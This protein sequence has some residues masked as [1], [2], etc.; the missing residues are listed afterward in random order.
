MAHRQPRTP[1]RL[2]PTHVPPLA[3]VLLVQWAAAC[4]E[5]SNNPSRSEGTGE[6]EGDAGSDAGPATGDASVDDDAGNP[7]FTP[8]EAVCGDGA[9]S[10]S[11][12]CDDGNEAS[13]DGCSGSCDEVEP[14]FACPVAGEYCVRF[15]ICGNARIEG[16]E[17]CDDR[18]TTGGDGCSA[19]CEREL[20][21]SCP[22]V[23][24]ACGAASCGDGYR[25]GFEGC[26][27]GNVDAGDGCDASCHLEEGHACPIPGAACVATV[28][29]DGVAEGTEDCDDMN[30][31]VGDGCTPVCTYEPS[32]QDGTCAAVCGDG[33][34]WAPETCDDG[35]SLSGDGCSSDCQ[36]EVGFACVEVE[37]AAPAE[38]QLP[39]TIRDF[40][41]ACGGGSR[42]PDDNGNAV[43]PYGHRDFE[44]YNGGG[45]GMVMANLGANGK[46][47]RIANN[48]T[49]SDASFG[50]WYVT[51][52]DYNRAHA[53]TLVLP[54]IGG[55]AYQ[56]INNDFFP[57]DALG[58][59]V[60]S[61]AGSPC[62][63][64]R[65]G[66]HNFHFTS[67]VRYWFKYSG[68]EILDFTGDDDVWVFI[69]GR[70]AVDL[71]GV[72]GPVNGSVDLSD[73]LV[74]SNLGITAG[75]IYGAVVF[76]AERHTVGSN[77]RLT[78]TNFNRAPSVCTSECGDGIVSSIEACD[79]G[80]DNDGSYGGCTPE[81][82][83]ASFCGDGIVQAAD[84]EI[85][86]DGLNL[87]AAD[88]CAPGC[89][90]MGGV[91]GD[92]VVQ[93]DDGEQCDDGNVAGGDG[94]SADC[95]IEIE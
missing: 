69:N 52:P 41:A 37:Q 67:E 74:A 33:F 72:H 45:A 19:D 63:P 65:S 7:T 48:V 84:G 91:C 61:C 64:L 60:E 68:N 39:V 54:A 50:Q 85:C 10:D 88:G 23:G 26:D 62:E 95:L 5:S 76:Q 92:G 12:A 83:F 24:A 25:V 80:D 14:G 82:G 31:D 53:S 43:P 79:D 9:R 81:C 49:Y 36:V 77:Y 75:N 56:F 16:D 38:V 6:T 42:L 1:V 15:V 70:L 71:G 2:Q 21:W 87:G 18:N 89:Q 32:C 29:G 3:L 46:P 13:G 57:L 73:P 51:D 8:P 40:V 11:E 30:P 90:A 17:T 27:D 4:G 86:D 58:F 34:V 55:G 47:Q 20:G 28:C 35:G 93:I 59:A 22:V 94:C 78:L 44:C 66:N